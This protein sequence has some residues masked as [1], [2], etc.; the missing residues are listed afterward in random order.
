MDTENAGAGLPA[1]VKRIDFENGLTLI[2]KEDHSSPVA[3]AHAWSRTGS[4]TEG[5]WTGAGMSHVLE[6]MLFKGTTHREGWRIDQEVQEAGGQMN[7]CTSFNYTLYYIDVP[8][9]GVKTAVDILCDI[10]QNATLPAEELEKEKQVILR[11]MDM[12]QDD[13]DRRSSRRLFETAY[14]VAPYRHPVIGYKD[15]FEAFTREDLMAYYKKMYAPNNL[16]IVVAGDIDPAAVEAQVREAFAGAKRGA[17]PPMVLPL[18]P[19]QTAAR[20]VEENGAVELC[21][22]HIAWHIPGVLH[23]DIPA[24][25]VAVAVLGSGRSS[26]LYRRLRE[27]LGLV[28]TI[29]SWVYSPGEQGLIGISAEIE[30]SKYEA[31]LEAVQEEIELLKRE[32]IPAAEL[33]KVK[34]QCVAGLYTARKTMSGQA[35]DLGSSWLTAGDLNFSDRSLARIQQVTAEDVQRVVCEWFSDKNKVLYSLLPEGFKRASGSQIGK[36]ERN[37]VQKTLLSNGLRLLVREDEQLPFVEFRIVFQGG[38][39]TEEESTAG[40]TLLM[41]RLMLKGTK[42]R[43]AEKISEE[44]ENVGGKIENGVSH[45]TVSFSAEVMKEDFDLGLDILSDVVLNPVFPADAL[46]L[47]RGMLL[48]DIRSEKDQM[49]PYALKRMRHELFGPW[50]FG[51]NTQ[52][53]E[54]SMTA[55]TRDD[56][57]A[58][59]K[60]LIQPDNCVLSV[61]GNVKADAVIRAVQA[62]FAQWTAAEPVRLTVPGEL[63][64]GQRQIVEEQADKKQAVVVMGYPGV[65]LKDPR[66]YPLVLLQE[67]CSDLGSRLFMRIRDELALAYYVGAFQQCGVQPGYFCFYAGTEPASADQVVQ[68]LFKQAESL[69][70]EGVTQAELD[71]AKAKIKGQR[72]IA[73]QDLGDVARVTAVNEICG[74]GY[75]YSEKEDALLQAVTLEQVRSAAADILKPEHCVISI[76]RAKAN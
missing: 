24:L 30:S 73:R 21:R 58:Q 13:P 57:V 74:L 4:I 34:K 12:G 61:F 18:E 17:L 40:Q 55:V 5:D 76:V 65:D 29:D 51:L 28:Q 63:K 1:G 8:A 37:P 23:P 9:S 33:E 6:H 19:P 38:L 52:G 39:V 32:L 2:L 16:F 60:R 36:I 48:A 43:S 47:E 66:I 62:K 26:R 53:S 67:I 35:M 7:A 3:T 46:E 56:V 14:H 11:E 50:S 71:R 69:V 41:S 59:W 20:I 72:S 45:G 25:G 44:I 42:T 70:K 22:S 75:D 27:E 31:A 54:Q 10:M 68:E 15:V 49:L 64:T